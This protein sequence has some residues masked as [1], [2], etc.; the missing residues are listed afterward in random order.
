MILN[1]QSL[2]DSPVVITVC[3]K[4]Y[5]TDPTGRLRY[6][7]EM[8]YRYGIKLIPIVLPNCSIPSD[9]Y[10]VEPIYIHEAVGGLPDHEV[11]EL[12]LHGIVDGQK[13]HA[14]THIRHDIV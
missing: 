10:D 1:A 6:E 2:R 13:L 4:H 8:A 14:R 3:S 11:Y 12:L 9:I 7:R 5:C